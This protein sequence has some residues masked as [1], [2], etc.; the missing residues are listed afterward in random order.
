MAL[1]TMTGTYA[2]RTA[3]RGRKVMPGHQVAALV[4]LGVAT[5]AQPITDCVGLSRQ[6]RVSSE[7][8]HIGD[9][10]SPDLTNEDIQ[11][12]LGLGL[13]LGLGRLQI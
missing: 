3:V 6:I 11:L 5:L 12:E 7:D 2:L 9:L 1:L 4:T 10:T 8:T 13:G